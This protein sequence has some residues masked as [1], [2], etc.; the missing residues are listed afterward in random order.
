MPA[1]FTLAV[2][3]AVVVGKLP[4]ASVITTV[5]VLYPIPP[6]VITTLELSSFKDVVLWKSV[7]LATSS[8]SN[9]LTLPAAPLE[10]SEVVTVKITLSKGSSNASSSGLSSPYATLWNVIPSN[11]SYDSPFFLSVTGL[12]FESNTPS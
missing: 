10:K 8:P 1:A 5:G 4:S 11:P 2:A 9:T 3:T 7:A 6:L 12:A